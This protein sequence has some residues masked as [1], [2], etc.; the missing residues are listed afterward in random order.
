MSLYIP[1]TTKMIVVELVNV[2]FKHV[3]RRFGALKG[4]I[5]DRGSLFTSEY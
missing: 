2:F 4:I 5:S 1:Y 3:V